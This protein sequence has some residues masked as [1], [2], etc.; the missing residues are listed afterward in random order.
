MAELG[1]VV[2]TFLSLAHVIPPLYA[3]VSSLREAPNE[4]IFF[5]NQLASLQVVVAG[6]E[7]LREQIPE[8]DFSE[9]LRQALS[10]V[11]KPLEE[12]TAALKSL[13][14]S[15]SNN[16]S[17]LRDRIR[18]SWKSSEFKQLCGRLGEYRSL[19]NTLLLLSQRYVHTLSL[20]GDNFKVNA[21]TPSSLAQTHLFSPSEY[22]L[23]QHKLLSHTSSATSNLER[24]T[25][26]IHEALRCN[27]RVET[28]LESLCRQQKSQN[29]Y[30]NK[31][32]ATMKEMMAGMPRN[33]MQHLE[34]S[35]EGPNMR[36]KSIMCFEYDFYFVRLIMRWGLLRRKRKRSLDANLSDDEFV[37]CQQ[38]PG[39]GVGVDIVPASW[40]LQ[41]AV[42][43]CWSFTCDQRGSPSFYPRLSFP[44]IVPADA[45]V[46]CY[47]ASNNVLSLKDMFISRKASVKDRTS[48]GW[49][50][51]HMAAAAG[52]LDSCKYL[53][54]HNADVTSAGHVG[55]LPLHLAAAYGHLDVIKLLV[56]SD[57]DPEAYN[58]HGF[59]AIFE[60]LHSPFI[61]DPALKAAIIIWILQQEHFVVDVNGQ[62]YQDDSILGWFVQN[63]P[64]GVNLLLDHKADVNNRTH[65]GSTPLHKAASS[66]SYESVRLL[67]NNGA[68]LSIIENDGSTALVRAA[69]R[70]WLDIVQQITL[71]PQE[72]PSSDKELQWKTA[73]KPVQL[74]CKQGM[75]GPSEV[76][77]QIIK[78]CSSS[79][80]T[81]QLKGS[82][83]LIA[84]Q[85]GYWSVVS[86]LQ[87]AGVDPYRKNEYG[88]RALVRLV[89]KG[90]IQGVNELIQ[91]GSQSTWIDD[92]LVLSLTRAA[93]AGHN[94]I[95]SYLLSLATPDFFGNALGSKALVA[96]A[97]HGHLEVVKTLL[98]TVPMHFW[99]R[100]LVR[101]SEKGHG[102]IVN[103]FLDHGV[104]PTRYDLGG[105]TAIV[106]A[107]RYGHVEVVKR[108][109][110]AGADPNQHGWYGYS[111]LVRA[112][113]NN[114]LEVVDCLLNAGA[115]PD[116]PESEGNCAMVRAMRQGHSRIVERLRQAGASPI[117]N[118]THEKNNGPSKALMKAAIYD[119]ES[120]L[121]QLLREG[122]DPNTVEVDGNTPISRACENGH[123]NIVTLLLTSG[124]LP[125]ALSNKAVSPLERAAEG[126]HL[127]VI[128][129]LLKAYHT[130]PIS[131]KRGAV[132]KASERG[133]SGIAALLIE[134]GVELQSQQSPTSSFGVVHFYVLDHW[135]KS[136][137]ENKGKADLETQSLHNVERAESTYPVGPPSWGYDG[138]LVARFRWPRRIV[139]YS[140][141]TSSNMRQFCSSVL[142]TLV[143]FLKPTKTFII[144]LSAMAALFLGMAVLGIE[145]LVRSGNRRLVA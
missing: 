99:Y 27:P 50:P 129:A 101:A 115:I 9:R 65:D 1:A 40:L 32:V 35:W 42:I 134:D 25:A 23:L 63:Y 89:Y 116:L 117:D 24:M 118:D 67:I 93:A 79:K 46:M 48:A 128:K 20:L 22:L 122:A 138:S 133:H 92:D 34:Y 81:E 61:T 2:I 17:S 96:A 140:D 47:A 103:I 71:Y 119:D 57:G 141:L 105:D 29:N 142:L 120:V 4:V 53:L 112:A 5:G 100:A 41:R 127:N 19:L 14:A 78:T 21:T 38:P 139:F 66:G 87:E 18:L 30:I 54:A 55:L 85:Q 58:Q 143:Y 104:H 74:L 102:D 44:V 90:D 37:A 97:R 131:E 75:P 43:S 76:V 145:S 12:D 110:G 121:M 108:L 88:Y 130:V 135:M 111:A 13:L 68:D 82:E 16:Q 59:N 28:S 114:H 125:Q 86:K 26:S 8:D 64:S 107:S 144:L 137:T 77:N 123:L 33:N 91:S 60:A 70:G 15:I 11:Q 136:M 7:R 51:L 36:Q 49:T 83:I 10:H 3:A 52:S 31:Q 80:T 126:G 98:P 109:L 95:V 39:F 56:E 124:A 113:Y 69:E 45:D 62:D 72:T 84:A 94:E 73:Y 132:F 106:R 6:L